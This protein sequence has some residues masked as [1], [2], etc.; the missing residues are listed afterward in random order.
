MSPARC[1]AA[2]LLLSSLAL[3]AAAQDSWTGPDKPKHFAVSLAAGFLAQGILGDRVPRWGVFAAALAPGVLKELSDDKVSVKD[4]VVD[5][6][7]AATGIY[8]SGLVI[9]SH[10]VSY[11]FTPA[12]VAWRYRGDLV[13]R[14]HFVGLELAF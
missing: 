12:A 10:A 4:L 14:R 3:P 13:V 11:R 1:L 8:V 6:V 9:R 7:G 2:A 5:A